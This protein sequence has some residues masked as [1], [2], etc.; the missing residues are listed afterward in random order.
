SIGPRLYGTPSFIAATEWVQRM[1]Q[2]WGIPVRREPVGTWRS[3]NIGAAHVEL[4]RPRIQNLEVEMLAWSPGTNNRPVEGDV[5]VMPQVSD[6]AAASAWLRTVRGKFV[7]VSPPE[8]MCRATQELERY[9]RPA[10]IESIRGQR[11][12]IF[13]DFGARARMFVQ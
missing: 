3:W 10:T 1:Y 6:T 11:R 2:G 12:A 4:I 8:I 5:V 7:M 13:Q 9:A